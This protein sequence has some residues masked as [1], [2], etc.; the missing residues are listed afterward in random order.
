[1]GL[2]IRSIAASAVL[3]AAVPALADDIVVEDAYAR[4][5]SPTART[6]AI[7]MQITNEGADDRLIGAASP[8]AELV[9][10]HAHLASGDGVMQ[11]KHASESF[12][13]PANDTLSLERGSNHVM[14]M[15]LTAPLVQDAT[16][17][18]TLT[19]EEA[20]DLTFNVRVDLERMPGEG[21]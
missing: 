21:K 17:P 10:L 12:D 20:R 13:L 9:Q 4:S 6:G 1:M 14:L 18:V 2:A 5:A 3:I 19:F 8:A 7:F 11:M 16:V 15:G